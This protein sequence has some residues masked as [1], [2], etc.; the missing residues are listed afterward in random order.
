[1]SVR[2]TPVLSEEE[3]SEL[4]RLFKEKVQ[5]KIDVETRRKAAVYFAKETMR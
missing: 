2:T 5:S 1:M 3:Q 4:K